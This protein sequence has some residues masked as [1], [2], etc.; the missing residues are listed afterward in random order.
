ML[1]DVAALRL[2][3]V[4]CKF[5]DFRKSG[6]MYKFNILTLSV[7]T[8]SVKRCS[9]LAAF[10]SVMYNLLEIL[11]DKLLSSVLCIG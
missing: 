6:V 4:L 8:L 3:L 2:S 7:L 5:A 1:G 9:C 11:E 10:I